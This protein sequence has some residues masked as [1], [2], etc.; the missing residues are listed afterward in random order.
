MTKCFIVSSCELVEIPSGQSGEYGLILQ[1]SPDVASVI[2]EPLK[3]FR[4]RPAA[5]AGCGFS[6]GTTGNVNLG[7]K[8]VNWMNYSVISAEPQLP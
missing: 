5:Y 3:R 6:P 7:D 2:G 8:S 4:L 1:S